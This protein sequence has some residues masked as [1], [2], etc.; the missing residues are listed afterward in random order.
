MGSA[1]LCGK[2]P[3]G[4]GQGNGKSDKAAPPG[5]QRQLRPVGRQQIIPVGSIQR[6]IG[7]GRKR[8]GIQLDNPSN[9]MF[10]FNGKRHDDRRRDHN[11]SAEAD[12]QTTQVAFFLLGEVIEYNNTETLFSVPANKKTEDYITGRFG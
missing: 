7:V 1:R 9:G 10:L 4:Q 6:R 2:Q 3:N 5:E 12:C 8:I 11:R